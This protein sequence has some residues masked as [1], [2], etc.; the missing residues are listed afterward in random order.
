MTKVLYGLQALVPP[1]SLPLGPQQL[2]KGPPVSE[3]RH[4]VPA[5]WVLLPLLTQHLPFPL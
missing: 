1:S 5:A 3:P 2:H 4:T